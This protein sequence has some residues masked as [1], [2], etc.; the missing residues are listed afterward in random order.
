MKS[1]LVR[2]GLGSISRID[3]CRKS[4]PEFFQERDYGRSGLVRSGKAAAQPQALGF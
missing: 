4:L 3:P 1:G 2:W